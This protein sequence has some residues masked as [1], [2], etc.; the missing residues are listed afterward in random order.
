MLRGVFPLVAPCSGGSV[1][2]IAMCDIILRAKITFSHQLKSAYKRQIAHNLSIW[3]FLAIFSKRTFTPSHHRVSGS[4]LVVA[5]LM[6]VKCRVTRVK[7][8]VIVLLCPQ[9]LPLLDEDV[10]SFAEDQTW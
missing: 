2:V 5:R 4:P 9:R 3:E 10:D 7:S 6:L 1:P 8:S